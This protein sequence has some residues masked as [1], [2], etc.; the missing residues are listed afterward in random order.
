MPKPH[1]TPQQSKK[2]QIFKDLARFVGYTSMIFLFSFIALNWSAYSTIVH[3]YFNPLEQYKAEQSLNGVVADKTVKQVLLDDTQKKKDTRKEYPQID[4]QVSPPDNR[5]IIPKIGK[6]IPIVNMDSE[7]DLNVL[8][9]EFEGKVQESL[10]G[11]VLHYPGTAEPGQYG[12]AFITGHSSYYPWDPGQYKDVFAL[13]D[14]LEVGDIY[15]IYFKQKKYAYK[16]REKKV[17]SPVETSVLDQPK[18]E[19]ISTLMTCTPVGTAINRL[20]IVAEQFNEK[21][22]NVLISKNKTQ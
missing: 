16:V 9:G 19:K 13:L 2:M 3:S 15:Y 11:G 17:V 20:I 8:P 14:K 22:K 5:L 1:E 18:E 12:N 7:L 10:R 4:L 21:G 6:N